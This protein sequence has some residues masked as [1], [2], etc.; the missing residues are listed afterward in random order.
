MQEHGSTGALQAA[1]ASVAA[2]VRLGCTRSLV[3]A[4]QGGWQV[5]HASAAAVCCPRQLCGC[6]VS[7]TALHLLYRP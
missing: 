4:A 5:Q 6:T 7:S 2:V 3:Q 1:A